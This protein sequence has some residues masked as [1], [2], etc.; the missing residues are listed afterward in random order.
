MHRF[1]S[2]HVRSTHDGTRTDG[3]TGGP[4]D[5]RRLG[6]P[7][8]PGPHDP[9]VGATLRGP[10]ATPNPRPASSLLRTG[11]LATPR[12]PRPRHQGVLDGRCGSTDRSYGARPGGRRGRRRGRPLRAV[13]RRGHDAGDARASVPPTGRRGSD[14]RRRPTGDAR[15]RGAM[16]SGHLQR[17]PR[18]PRHAGRSIVAHSEDAARAAHQGSRPDRPRMWS[19]GHAYDRAGGLRCPP[20]AARPFGPAARGAHPNRRPRLDRSLP[21][22]P[23]RCAGLP[24]RRDP[25]GGD[26]IDRGGRVDPGRVRSTRARASRAPPPGLRSRASTSARISSPRR[27][28]SRR[29]SVGAVRPHLIALVGSHEPMQCPTKRSTSCIG[30]RTSS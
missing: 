14:R 21:P 30:L 1:A 12:S 28:R 17:R 3:L 16:E 19:E 8:H 13:A 20:G 22:S 29:C 4:A 24:A 15:D 18:A 6:T 5:R 23:G 25:E 11:D 27:I 2:P 26:R 10:G 9:F 7:R